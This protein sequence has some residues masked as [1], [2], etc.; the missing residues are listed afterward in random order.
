VFDFRISYDDL[1]GVSMKGLVFTVP[2]M[3]LIWT[4]SACALPAV[5]SQGKQMDAPIT[6]AEASKTSVSG[7]FVNAEHPTQ[8]K[9]RIGTD[10]GMRYLELDSSFKTD[11]GPDLKV[12]L[13]KDKKLDLKLKEGDYVSLGALQKV[14]GTQR[15]EI[16]KNIDLSKYNSVAIW[17]EQFNATF[18][19]AQLKPVGG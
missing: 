1:P 19:Y 5:D 7:N 2:A 6:I 8:G 9:A 12:V 18:G 11:Q 17:C 4:A 15:Y 14:S 3:L 13:H 16:P 10:N